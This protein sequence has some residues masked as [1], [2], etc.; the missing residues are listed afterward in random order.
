MCIIRFLSCGPIP[1]CRL[2]YAGE[3]DTHK[4]AWEQINGFLT[5]AKER[6]NV[7]PNRLIGKGAPD[8]YALRMR[9]IVK[10]LF[11]IFPSKFSQMIVSKVT[12]SKSLCQP[13]GF[14]YYVGLCYVEHGSSSFPDSCHYWVSNEL[15][16]RLRPCWI[17][18]VILVVTQSLLSGAKC[19]VT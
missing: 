6:L 7:T 2:H 11:S 5:A 3:R 15:Q 17:T 16:E 8:Y 12:T 1:S 13:H 4:W 14:L 19:C 18:A 9:K 10:A